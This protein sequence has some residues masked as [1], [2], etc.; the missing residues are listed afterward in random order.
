[1]SVPLAVVRG[2]LTTPPRVVSAGGFIPFPRVSPPHPPYSEI[3]VLCN[4]VTLEEF[5]LRCSITLS[6]SIAL[7]LLPPYSA[8]GNFLAA[9]AHCHMDRGA[10]DAK[11]AL[12]LAAPSTM[13]YMHVSSF[14]SYD[15]YACTPIL[16]ARLF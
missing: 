6:R 4:A 5:A 13:H 11:P 7:S 12:R 16:D 10:I 1:V 14:I 15:S 8:V 3:Q 9:V 2:H